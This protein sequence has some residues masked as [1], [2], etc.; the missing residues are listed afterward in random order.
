MQ[1]AFLPSVFAGSGVSATPPTVVAGS[2]AGRDCTRTKRTVSVAR[3]TAG[4][5]PRHRPHGA[6]R[7]VLLRSPEG[8]GALRYVEAS[9]AMN[10]MRTCCRRRARNCPR[11][12]MTVKQQASGKGAREHAT[13]KGERFRAARRPE[14][15]VTCSVR[16]PELH[17]LEMDRHAHA[18]CSSPRGLKRGSLR[19]RRCGRESSPGLRNEGLGVSRG[20]AKSLDPFSVWC[21]LL[22]NERSEFVVFFW[23]VQVVHR[24]GWH[25]I[26]VLCFSCRTSTRSHE[27]G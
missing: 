12:E 5:R 7:G 22:K 3:R 10:F 13:P 8:P 15:A 24:H 11:R 2:S 14:L 25:V 23:M 26:V 9:M 21:T 16:H 1:P 6:M 20:F 19:S 18:L 17:H 27:C 4:G